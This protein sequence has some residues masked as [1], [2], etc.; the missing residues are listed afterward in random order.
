MKKSISRIKNKFPNACVET[1]ERA[2][3]YSYGKQNKLTFQHT[4][5]IKKF[6]GKKDYSEISEFITDNIPLRG[7]DELV[8]AFECLV[9]ENDKKS[10]GVVYTPPEIRRY[11]S[12]ETIKTEHIPHVIDPAC[13]CG[14][15]LI[16]ATQLLHEKYDTSYKEIYENFLW[17]CDIDSHSI[18]KC[19]ILLE[20]LAFQKEG[21]A[22]KYKY[23]LIVGN[24][25]E[26]LSQEKY[27]G[28]YDVVIG[29]PPYVRSKNIDEKIKK[30]IEKWDVVSGNVDLYIPF[31]QLGIELL[32]TGGTLGYISP[33]TYLQSV[34]GR[35]L[36]NYVRDSKC[37]LRIM[38][39]KETQKFAD[40]THY[41]CITFIFGDR[42]NSKIEYAVCEDDLD[43]CQYTVYDISHYPDNM[44]WRF[45]NQEIDQ[46]VYQIEHQ[47]DK[48]D[49]Y[50]IRNGLATLCNELFFFDV[51]K[52]T[53]QYYIRNYDGKEYKI[54]KGICISIA[55]P[56]IMRSEMDLIKKGEKAIYPYIDGKIIHEA[57]FEKKYPYAYSFLEKHKEKL[58][59]RDKGKIHDYPAWYAY[60]RTQGMNNQGTKILIPY[61]ADRGVAI[62]S[63]DHDLLFYCGYAVFSKD[64]DFL[65]ILK[66][67]IES[68][69][70]WFYIKMTSKPYS[71][72]Y[73]ALAKNYIKNFGIPVLSNKETKHLIQSKGIAREKLIAKL[74][75]LDYKLVRQYIEKAL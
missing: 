6:L 49:N 70:F 41:T 31:Y 24:A 72:G 33:N 66:I 65:K 51:V 47:P 75:N 37:N 20:L 18:D 68:N 8:V 61:M 15:F 1:I 14:A 36:R 73:M 27:L 25:L 67:F 71:K 23:N 55:K 57:I 74:Y 29:N 64:V 7:L 69:V 21:K 43:N 52:E 53:I 54:E 58:L 59:C 26:I 39:F 42:R 45:G 34:N 46:M 5:E 44:E 10:N 3:V 40:A 32:N 60:G 30:S 12:K 50:N 9:T 17:G 48:L 38:N 4:F 13:G 11:I 35:A 62:I 16:S 19:R 22:C 56:N 28:K 2:F 63:Q